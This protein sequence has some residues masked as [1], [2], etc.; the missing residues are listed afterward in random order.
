V[1]RSPH[2]GPRDYSERAARSLPAA[3]EPIRSIA[4]L[5][6]ALRYGKNVAA[7]KVANC[8]AWS[9]NWNSDEAHFLLDGVCVPFAALSVQSAPP[10]QKPYAKREDVDGFIRQMVEKHSFVDQELKFLFLARGA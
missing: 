5:Y 9:G 7:D 1:A 10:A 3:G 4:D 6:I 8:V 2:E